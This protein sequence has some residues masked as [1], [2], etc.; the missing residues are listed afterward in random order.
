MRQDS[1]QVLDVSAM[2]RDKSEH[3]SASLFIKNALD[4]G[5]VSN[6]TAQNENLIPNGY[7]QFQPRTY[8]RQ[9]GVELRYNWF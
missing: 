3:Y 1:Y 5:Y 8:E 2:L 7:I 4:E 6:I 9:V